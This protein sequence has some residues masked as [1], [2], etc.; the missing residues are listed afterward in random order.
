MK[1]RL[2]LALPV[3]AALVLGLAAC[4]PSSGGSGGGD[5]A[6]TPEL[7]IWVD[8][9]REPAAK[10][11]QDAVKDEVD[12]KIEVIDPTTLVSKIQLFNTTGKGWPDVVFSGAPN[13][14]ATWADPA[15]GYA[16]ALNDTVAPEI[17]E[18][19][20]TA[21]DW[22]EIDGKFYCLKND[23]AQTVLWYD[24]AIFSELGLKVPTTMDEFAATAMQLKGTGYIA[25]TLGNNGFYNGFLWPNGCPM[26]DV[27]DPN[28]IRIAPEAKEC[29]DV[30]E[31]LQPL[32][33]AGVMATQDP[34]DAAFLKAYP[35][36][37]KVA[38]TVGPSWFGEFVF[39]P[40]ESWGIPA[41]RIAA[42]EMPKWAGQDEAYSGE[43]GGGV[44]VASSHSKFPQ[45]AADAVTFLATDNSIQKDAVTYP[46]Y[47]PALEVWSTAIS[48]DPYYASDVIPAMAAQ[49]NRISPAVK[50]VRFNADGAVTSVLSTEVIGGA[51]LATAVTDFQKNLEQLAE[52]SGYTVVTK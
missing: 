37:G 24:T 26:T 15:N 25:G 17:F 28:T 51:P 30:S 3:A 9:T 13:D 18:G 52:A 1:K 19:Y 12:V 33:D 48:A 22:C 11:Y 29:T 32:V 10:I 16:A 27:V 42:A 31:L 38:M 49:A 8:A 45:A 23:L 5:A 35:Q 14:F 21:N 36:A 39:K 46:A 43:W 47:G 41:G 20:G 7:L 2:A 34:F 50:P 4:S 6:G 40:A 44:W